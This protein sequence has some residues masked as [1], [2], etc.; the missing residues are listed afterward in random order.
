MS[1]NAIEYMCMDFM[2]RHAYTYIYM[3]KY[4]IYKY[5]HTG[6]NDIMEEFLKRELRIRS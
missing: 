5:M 2:S 6:Y 4:F 3:H 1:I